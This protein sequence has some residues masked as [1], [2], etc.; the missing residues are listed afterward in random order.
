MHHE[1]FCHGSHLIRRGEHFFVEPVTEESDAPC[2]RVGVEIL[3]LFW[4]CA[5]EELRIC[6]LVNLVTEMN[7]MKYK[8][9]ISVIPQCYRADI[10]IILEACKIPAVIFEGVRGSDS[11]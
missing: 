6:F 10:G 4:R 9:F 3:Q 11:D 8:V 7:E 5:G 1:L 2:A